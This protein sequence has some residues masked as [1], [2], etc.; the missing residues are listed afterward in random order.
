VSGLL[1]FAADAAPL[2]QNPLFLPKLLL[3]ALGVANA[4]VFRVRWGHMTGQASAPV[5]ARIQAVLSLAVWVAAATFGRLL[6]YV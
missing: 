2:L 5:G 6:A 1:L 3:I 4:V